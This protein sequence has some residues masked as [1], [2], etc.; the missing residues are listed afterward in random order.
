MPKSELFERHADRYDD[1]FEANP[2][3]Y[4]SEVEALRRLL[5]EPG[6]GVEIGVGSGRFASP[7]GMQVGVDP[8]SEMLAHAR[9]RGIDVVKGVAEAL[10][11]PADTFDTALLV[12]TICFV[13]DISRTITEARGVLRPDGSFVRRYPDAA[14]RH[15]DVRMFRSR[16]VTFVSS[17]DDRLSSRIRRRGLRF[18]RHHGSRLVRQRVRLLD[19]DARSRTVGRVRNRVHR[20]R[21]VA[22][23][24]RP[25]TGRFRTAV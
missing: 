5:P 13:D 18:R 15:H 3:A 10:P 2:D 1:W 21:S 24:L 11:F 20:Y 25:A 8:A 19:A 16:R 6:F 9:D 7:L 12:T 14:D 17:A 23:L 4:R 22:R